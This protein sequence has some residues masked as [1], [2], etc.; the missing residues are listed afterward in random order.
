[1]VLGALFLLFGGG[2]AGLWSLR[3]QYL[4]SEGLAERSPR[5][6]I[7]TVEGPT[8]GAAS[9]CPRRPGADGPP[10][11]DR[12]PTISR[13]EGVRVQSTFGQ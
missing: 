1:M 6:L 2:L 4:T 9:S 7:G 3:K 5:L 12:E 8:L 13:T 11:L 10:G